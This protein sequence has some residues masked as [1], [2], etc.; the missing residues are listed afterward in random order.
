M[1]TN[2][3]C[4]EVNK[5]KC[6]WRIYINSGKDL[7]VRKLEGRAPIVGFLRWGVPDW[8][9]PKR[10]AKESFSLLIQ[11]HQRNV[12]THQVCVHAC[13]S[14]ACTKPLWLHHCHHPD[15][16]QAIMMNNMNSM[17]MNTLRS[18]LSKLSTRSYLLD[19]SRCLT[20]CMHLQFCIIFKRLEFKHARLKIECSL[21]K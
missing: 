14:R 15:H 6:D 17:I 13:W 5:Y 10:L 16:R 12:K 1:D 19:S 9:G 4:S 3:V 7:A 2:R 18:N 21:F 20:H 8:N 11:Y